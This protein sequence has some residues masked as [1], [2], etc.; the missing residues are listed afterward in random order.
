MRNALA[1]GCLLG[2]LG[3]VDAIAQDAAESAILL[4]GSGTAQT[5]AQRSLGSAAASSI[6]RASG[7]IN[8]SPGAVTMRS[9]HAR[10]RHSGAKGIP[11]VV[12][13][14][15]DPLRG[16][17]APV[18]RLENGATLRISGGLQSTAAATCVS[19]CP[20]GTSPPKH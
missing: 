5:R 3:T 14:G 19:G 20:Q 9:H 13:Q 2:L 16:T 8:A 10:R 7:A 1:I 17:D 15:G 4:G 11:V 12:P 18:Y 6:G